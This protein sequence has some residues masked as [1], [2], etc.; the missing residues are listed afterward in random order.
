[1]LEL[2]LLQLGTGSAGTS[3]KSS[4]F[5]SDWGHKINFILPFQFTAKCETERE[6]DE[7]SKFVIMSSP[8]SEV[9]GFKVSCSF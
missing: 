6:H 4:D 1:M 8:R 2:L 7:Y 3:C 9:E 5:F